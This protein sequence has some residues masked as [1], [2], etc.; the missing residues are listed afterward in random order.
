M[1]CIASSAATS[2]SLY[3]VLS[4]VPWTDATA[5]AVAWCNSRIFAEAEPCFPPIVPEVFVLSS[6]SF[7][8]PSS[9]FWQPPKVLVLS[10]LSCPLFARLHHRTVQRVGWVSSKQIYFANGNTVAGGRACMHASKQRQTLFA[11][12][13]KNHKGMNTKSEQCCF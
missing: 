10:S 7:R 13:V 9:S 2:Y 3:F 8:H 11:R 6:S 5:L 4:F 1:A 12:S